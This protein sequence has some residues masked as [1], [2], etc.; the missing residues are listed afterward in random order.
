MT[1]QMRQS[2]AILQ[3]PLAELQAYVAQQ[4]TE[5]CLLEQED[6]RDEERPPEEPDQD[7]PEEMSTPDW[8]EYFADGRDLGVAA[9]ERPEPNVDDSAAAPPSLQDHLL[10]QIRLL[11]WPERARRIGEF[12]VG[13]LDEDGYLQCTVAE[14]AA[15]LGVAGREVE[16]VLRSIQALEPPGVGA[17]D[18][19]EC[20]LIQL[21]L[22]EDPE[23]PA[24]HLAAE[25]IGACLGDLAA[26]RYAKIAG[27]LGVPPSDV[28]AALGLIRRLDPRPGRNFGSADPGYILPDV[29]LRYIDDDCLITV[30]DGTATKLR[31]SPLYRRMLAGAQA[32]DRETLSYLQARLNA[33]VALIKGIEQRQATLGKIAE[34]ITRLQGP[35]LTERN[36][37]LRPL[38]LREVAAAFRTGTV[39]TSFRGYA[40]EVQGTT[41]LQ[42][43]ELRETE[44]FERRDEAA[45]LWGALRLP[46][47]VVEA[48]API[49]YTYFVDLEK[50]WRFQLEGQ[51]VFVRAPAIE[52][53]R[54][55]VDV[56]ALRYEVRAGSVFRD[57]RLVQERLRDELT[58][59]ALL[60]ARQR[61]P[62]VRE[63]GRRKVEAFV[64]TWLVQRFSDGQAYRARVRFAD[65]PAGPE[66]PRPPAPPPSLG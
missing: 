28:H 11:S 50:E 23:G 4:L 66:S 30:N 12:L 33:A 19:R 49:A 48:R 14:C 25:I 26:G 34:A 15:A 17:R 61:L 2:L 47:V 53:N 27:K 18:L 56:S 6:E 40:T 62:F 42:F 16:E 7:H 60:R 57:E 9:G 22:G 64:E 58:A 31:I 3:M 13:N 51:E 37:P 32:A 55:A 43:A 59:L 8:A 1:P 20:L 5:N 65:E 46:D 44:V 54:P 45:I 29:T 21:K 10:A 52:W 24:A 35:F 38:T 63:T 39:T 41:R 36:A